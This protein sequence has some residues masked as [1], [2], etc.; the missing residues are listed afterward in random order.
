MHAWRKRFPSSAERL[1]RWFEFIPGDPRALDPSRRL[2]DPDE[3]AVE[4][5]PRHEERLVVED[6][7]SQRITARWADPRSRLRS[8]SL[9]RSLTRRS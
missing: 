7:E 8:H 3:S 2:G 9:A 5:R 4:A 6:L 1:T